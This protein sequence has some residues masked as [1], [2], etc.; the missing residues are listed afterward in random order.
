M[1]ISLCRGNK[2]RIIGSINEAY[3]SCK[4]L[5]QGGVTSV[6]ERHLMSLWAEHRGGILNVDAA[7][8]YSSLASSVPLRVTV[9]RLGVSY[10]LGNRYD[11]QSLQ[12]K[13]GSPWS[14]SFGQV[15]LAGLLCISCTTGGMRLK[16]SSRVRDE[17]EGE[18]VGLTKCPD[19]LHQKVYCGE[20]DMACNMS[21]EA[22]TPLFKC[23][24]RAAE[25]GNPEDKEW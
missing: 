11:G 8:D 12:K 1:S 17:L 15:K 13:V 9:T 23:G 3:H 6:L 14:A 24:R 25:F 19:D 2:V 22:D 10:Q 18:N 21:K 20:T 16:L 5:A 4:L 7:L